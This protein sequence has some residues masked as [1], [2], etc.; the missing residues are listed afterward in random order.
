M[1]S[2]NGGEYL[3]LKTHLQSCRISQLT[4][5]PHTPKHNGMAELPHRHIVETDLSL[6]SHASMP[7]SFWTFGF[8]TAVYLINR[9]PTST[10][11]NI[12]PY[13]KLFHK[14][15][16]YDKLPSLGAYA[17]LGFVPTHPINLTNGPNLVLL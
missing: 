14:N 9:L 8:S 3:K 6:L 10:I 5:P 2:D 11:G 4:T 7:I 15:P 12:S 1:Y 16:N 13:H 17:I